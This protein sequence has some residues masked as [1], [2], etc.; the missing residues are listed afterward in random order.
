MSTLKAV[1]A[2]AAVTGVVVVGYK[3]IQ[4]YRRK[5]AE[6]AIIAGFQNLADEMEKMFNTEGGTSNF[7]WKRG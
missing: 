2:A 1:A 5:R 7:E 3:A 4:H 6:E